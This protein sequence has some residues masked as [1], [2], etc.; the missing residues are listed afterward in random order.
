[1]ATGESTQPI[2]IMTE[3]ECWARLGNHVIGRLVVAVGH[4]PDVFPVNYR[5]D[6]DEIVVRTAE[7]TKLAAAIMGGLV[8]FEIDDF[9][10]LGHAGWSVVVHGTARESVVLED[11]MHD[12]E[13]DTN[14]WAAGEKGRVMRI[15]PERITGRRVLAP[16]R[17]DTTT[18]NS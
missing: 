17:T 8:A 16:V 4:Q 10:E 2:E 11:V 7:G 18:P 12:D 3:G 15:S 13:I 6:E 1:M 5:V 9:D 14:P